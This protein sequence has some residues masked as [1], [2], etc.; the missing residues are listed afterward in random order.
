MSFVLRF[1][2]KRSR[3]TANS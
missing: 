2:H 1:L 3:K